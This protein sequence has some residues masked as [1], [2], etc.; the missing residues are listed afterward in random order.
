MAHTTNDLWQRPVWLFRRYIVIRLSLSLT[1]KNVTQ[2]VER[3]G[4]MHLLRP[5]TAPPHS[6]SRVHD[7]YPEGCADCSLTHLGSETARREEREK[8][9]QACDA[10]RSSFV[11][12]RAAPLPLS[13]SGLGHDLDSL[14][15]VDARGRRAD[16]MS[17]L[18]RVPYQVFL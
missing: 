18:S 1:P 17:A 16:H 11:C 8:V 9:G 5:R 4:A 2:A 12:I 10:A 14:M 3:T 6:L 7:P 15:K 13:P